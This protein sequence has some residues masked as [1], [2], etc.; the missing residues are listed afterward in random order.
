MT[1]IVQDWLETSPPLDGR[2]AVKAEKLLAELNQLRHDLQADPTDLEWV[3]LHHAFC[4]IS[5]RMG[6]FQAYLDEQ[7]RLGNLSDDIEA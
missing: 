7:V 2:T 4:F 5:Y 1:T 6:E 3:T